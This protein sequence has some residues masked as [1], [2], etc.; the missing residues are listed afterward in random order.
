MSGITTTATADNNNKLDGGIPPCQSYGTTSPQKLGRSPTADYNNPRLECIA[1]CQSHGTY[2]RELMSE[3][4]AAGNNNKLDDGIPPC[5]SF[6][7]GAHARR[8]LE[9]SRLSRQGKKEPVLD[10]L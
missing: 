3:T 5:Q 4:T 7:I 8:L 1:S 10:K 2:A 6:E 9:V